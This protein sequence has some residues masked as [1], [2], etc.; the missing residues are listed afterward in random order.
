[1]PANTVDYFDEIT[2]YLANEVDFADELTDWVSS[3]LQRRADVSQSTTRL[4]LFGDV[5]WCHHGQLIVEMGSLIAVHPTATLAVLVRARDAPNTELRAWVE[6]ANG[7]DDIVLDL[8]DLDTALAG[9]AEYG[10]LLK[11]KWRTTVV[12][13]IG[14]MIEAGT[15]EDEVW[16]SGHLEMMPLYSEPDAMTSTRDSHREGVG[17]LSLRVV[18]DRPQFRAGSGVAGPDT[19]VDLLSLVV[20]PDGLVY[21]CPGSVGLPGWAVATVRDDFEAAALMTDEAAGLFDTLATSGPARFSR[22][23]PSL[24]VVDSNLPEICVRHRGLLGYR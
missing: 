20:S 18:E 10:F 19:C 2:I 9:A 1:M 22:S 6:S 11:G 24:N 12:G 8:R 17:R 23:D 16:S 13:D 4:K 15:F 5:D 3:F 7:P 14:T 21:P